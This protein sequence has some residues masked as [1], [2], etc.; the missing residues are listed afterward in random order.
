M[1]VLLIGAGAVGQVYGRHL[2]LGGARVS[3]FV[4]ESHAA[5][6]RAGFTMYPLRRRT[7]RDPV[8]F[9]PDAVLTT[10]REAQGRSWDQVWLCVPTPALE[11]AWLEDLLGGIDGAT[12]VVLQPDVG[13]AER[14]ASV[15]GEDRIVSGVIAM[16]SYQ[17]PLPG[18]DVPVP[19]VAYVLPVGSRSRF[20]GAPDWVR[21]VVEALRAGGCPARVDR[22]V[23]RALGFSA[24]LLMAQVVGLEGA[25]WSLRAFL[26]GPL[27]PVAARAARQAQALVAEDLGVRPPLSRWLVR[28]LPVRLAFALV[29]FVVPFDLEAYLRYHFTKVH[30]QTRLLMERY[31]ATASRTRVPADAVRDLYDRVLARGGV[32]RAE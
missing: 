23:R 7:R 8:R 1:D 22:D 12:V 4:K 31:L 10:A 15:V 17:A 26:R 20:S 28:P 11:G 25:G 9:V 19:G 27:L 16:M 18:E 5:E 24:A 14:I 13:A 32:A 6:A 30:R 2:A 3:V 21:Q 29:R